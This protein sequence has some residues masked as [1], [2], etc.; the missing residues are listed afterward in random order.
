MKIS[1]HPTVGYHKQGTGF[2]DMIP[3]QWNW[4][5]HSEGPAFG[6]MLCCHYPEILNNI[7]TRG[8]TMY[9]TGLA[10]ELPTV[11]FPTTWLSLGCP[12][13][14]LGPAKDWLMSAR[15]NRPSLSLGIRMGDSPATPFSQKNTEMYFVLS[16]CLLTIVRRTQLPKERFQRL[17][18]NTVSQWCPLLCAVTVSLLQWPQD[19]LSLVRIPL[20]DPGC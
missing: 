6:L 12:G 2:M 14:H 19:H 11:K 16:I 10:H 1:F 5:R 18:S 17:H 3:E 8:P 9:V 13:L 20:T 15:A 7:L 4:G